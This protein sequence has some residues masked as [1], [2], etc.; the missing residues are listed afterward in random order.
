VYIYVKTIGQYNKFKLTI[1]WK[2]SDRRKWWLC[3]KNYTFWGYFVLLSGHVFFDTV[4]V[5]NVIL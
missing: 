2:N 3:K 1:S 5:W 4:S